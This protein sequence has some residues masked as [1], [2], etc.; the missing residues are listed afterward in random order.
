M[1][2]SMMPE[3]K[4]IP[5]NKP[6]KP[7]TIRVGNLLTIPVKR[8]SLKTGIKKSSFEFKTDAVRESVFGYFFACYLIGAHLNYRPRE[9]IDRIVR[10]KLRA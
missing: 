7:Q 8:Y 5:A 10:V 3:K 6:A 1:V 4:E 2:C 9:E